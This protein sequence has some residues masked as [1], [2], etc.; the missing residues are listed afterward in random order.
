MFSEIDN[1]INCLNMAQVERKIDFLS[2]LSLEVCLPPL[3]LLVT[4][5]D[6]RSANTFSPMWTV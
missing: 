6:L 2:G 3:P 1:T 5:F 4:P